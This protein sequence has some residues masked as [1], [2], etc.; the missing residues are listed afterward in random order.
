VIGRRPVVGPDPRSRNREVKI[1]YGL[2]AGD[3]PS[4]RDVWRALAV[5]RETVI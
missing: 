2:I 4:T 1:S 5:D 3:S